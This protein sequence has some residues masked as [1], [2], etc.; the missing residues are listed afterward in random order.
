MEEV[1]VEEVVGK[2]TCIYTHTVSSGGDYASCSQI[3]NRSA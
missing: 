1:S 3:W 2:Q